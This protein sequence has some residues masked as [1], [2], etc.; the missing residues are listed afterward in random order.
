MEVLAARL[1]RWVAR[2]GKGLFALWLVAAA[3]LLAGAPHL[4]AQTVPSPAYQVKAVFLFH[5]ASFAEWP[6]AA[7]PTPQ[8]PLVIGVLGDDPFGAYLDETVRNERVNRRDLVVRRYQRVEDIETCHIL[9][10]SASENER[11]DQIL[12]L[13]RGRSILTVGEASR[14]AQAGGMIQF[15]TERD[16]IRLR[17]NA[18]AA[19][20]ADVKISSRLL[21]LAEIVRTQRG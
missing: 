1:S 13:L 16:K 21:R 4:S 17:I 10:V 8:T 7:F 5:F 11:L 18:D 15:F 2:C 20:A 12:P 19:S 3:V 14:F 9:Y 6:P